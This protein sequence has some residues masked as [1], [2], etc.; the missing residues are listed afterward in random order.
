MLP[1]IEMNA[2]KALFPIHCLKSLTR[3]REENTLNCL[4]PRRDVVF[5][6]VHLHMYSIQLLFVYTHKALDMYMHA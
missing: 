5:I 3:K 2:L 4:L 1:S 6:P